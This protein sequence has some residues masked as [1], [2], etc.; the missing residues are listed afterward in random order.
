MRDALTKLLITAANMTRGAPAIEAD[1]ID[2]WQIV[3]ESDEVEEQWLQ[4][5]F[6]RYLQDA[7]FFPAPA[8]II[9]I[10]WRLKVEHMEHIPCRA[11]DV[12]TPEQLAKDAADAARARERMRELFG[13]EQPWHTGTGLVKA[14]PMPMDNRE[15]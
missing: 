14:M 5:A 9:K 3:L 11:I 15:H 12:P 4:P 7:T 13:I 6:V 2:M 10:V 8:E 1:L